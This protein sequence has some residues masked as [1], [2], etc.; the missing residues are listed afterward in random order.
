M[1][2][3]Q[4]SI[5][6]LQNKLNKKTLESII[7]EDGKMCFYKIKTKFII[8]SCFQNKYKN[9]LKLNKKYVL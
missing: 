8:F 1:S 9:I 5:D 2:L 3:Y 6:F 4:I 7:R